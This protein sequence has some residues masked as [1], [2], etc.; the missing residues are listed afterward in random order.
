MVRCSSGAENSATLYTML[1]L[2]PAPV[3]LCPLEKPLLAPGPSVD[4]SPLATLLPVKRSVPPFM[5]IWPFPG[6]LMADRALPLSPSVSPL[7]MSWIGL[8]FLLLL[9][10]FFPMS[11]AVT[12]GMSG[13]NE[14]APDEFSPKS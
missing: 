9:G 5:L 11:Q 7:G 6:S 2:F 8:L 4:A 14:L 1:L 3:W 10:S 12:K 13:R